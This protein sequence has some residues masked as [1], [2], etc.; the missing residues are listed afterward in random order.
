MHQAARVGEH[1]GQI[2]GFKQS[3]PL[4]KKSRTLSGR[5][6]MLLCVQLIHG[7]TASPEK[8]FCFIAVLEIS[9][10]D[11]MSEQN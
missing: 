6:Y 8:R 2:G 11:I 3:S 10:H 7:A 5:N 1:S 9:C 4:S